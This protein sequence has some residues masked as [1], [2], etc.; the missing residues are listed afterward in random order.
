MTLAFLALLGAPYIYIYIYDIS[1]LRVNAKFGREDTF[2]L[3]I[4]KESLHQDSN[5]NGDRILTSPHQKI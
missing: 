1:S 3:T 2:K 4:W 5:D